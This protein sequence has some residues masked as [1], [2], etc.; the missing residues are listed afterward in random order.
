MK[1]IFANKKNFFVLNVFNNQ[2]KIEI[3]NIWHV[4]DTIANE[5]EKSVKLQGWIQN[6]IKD[7]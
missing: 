5:E 7:A 1:K 2:K 4:V 6:K 3:N